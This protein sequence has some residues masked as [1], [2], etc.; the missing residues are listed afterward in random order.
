MAGIA[1]WH[2]VSYSLLKYWNILCNGE[3]KFESL[4]KV[5]SALRENGGESKY[6]ITMER[7]TANLG[8]IKFWM[9]SNFKADALHGD[10]INI[11]FPYNKSLWNF[12]LK[13]HWVFLLVKVF[14]CFKAIWFWLL[15]NMMNKATNSTT[16]T[17]YSTI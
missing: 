17:Q 7:Q 16:R 6:C 2:A 12:R 9:V 8:R 11:F 15:L 1:S 5:C 3:Y 10:T 14:C 4:H 13:T